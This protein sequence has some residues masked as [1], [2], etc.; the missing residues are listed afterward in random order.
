MYEALRR[1]SLLSG[2]KSR[3]LVPGSKSDV[4]TRVCTQVALFF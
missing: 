3:E 1:A 4:D 2:E